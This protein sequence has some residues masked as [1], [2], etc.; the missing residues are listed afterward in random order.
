MNFGDEFTAVTPVCFGC[1]TCNIGTPFDFEHEF[2]CP[3][4]YE[5]IVGS[6]D[7]SAPAARVT[8]V[9]T[10][11]A[12]PVVPE[13]E[14]LPFNVFLYATMDVR[15]ATI[16]RSTVDWGDGHTQDFVWQEKEGRFV[17]PTHDYLAGRYTATV[18]HHYDSGYCSTD[19]TYSTTFQ[20]PLPATPV[21]ATTWGH[22][23]TLYRN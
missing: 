14:V 13:M 10:E 12:T 16:A 23:K 4:T 19:L 3:G 8:V 11:P 21:R 20:V 2:V 17:T 6:L 9:V 18:T 15:P 5:I 7:D 1:G 22:V